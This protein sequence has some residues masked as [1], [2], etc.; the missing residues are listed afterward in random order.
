MSSLTSAIVAIEE[1]PRGQGGGASGRRL[2]LTVRAAIGGDL[3]ASRTQVGDAFSSGLSVSSGSD[4]AEPAGDV[5]LGQL[6]LGLVKI[7]RSRRISTR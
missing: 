6:F 2:G 7:C 4:S 3:V 1:A 5:V